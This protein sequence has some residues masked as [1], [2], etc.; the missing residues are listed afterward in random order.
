MNIVEMEKPLGVIASLGGQTAINLAEPSPKNA[1]YYNYFTTL[2]LSNERKTKYSFEEIMEELDIPQPKGKAVTNIEDGV[3]AADEIGYPV[4]VRPSYVLG[5]EQCRL[6]LTN[7]H[8]RYLKTAVKI[9]E[10][11][12]YWLINISKVKKWKWMPFV[13]VPAYSFRALW[14]W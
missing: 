5:G 7:H 14:N 4:L 9:N 12:L 2:L 1:A 11:S 13:M 10:I 8:A 6:W 3:N